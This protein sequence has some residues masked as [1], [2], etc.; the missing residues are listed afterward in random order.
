MADTKAATNGVA[1]GKLERYDGDD[2]AMQRQL[3]RPPDIEQDMKEMER[4]KRVEMIMNSQLFREELERIIESQLSEGYT[5]SS[6]AALQQVTDLLLPH[7][8]KQSTLRGGRCLVPINDMRG[9]DGLRCSKGEKVL[10]CKTAALCRLVDAHGWTSTGF[11]HVTVRL[12]QD[13]EHFLVNP[14]G[15]LY[16][17]VTASSLL[18]LDMQ[19]NVID[20]G[21]TT[22]HFNR[23]WYARH[24][25]VHAGRPD[26]KCL[27]H[28]QHPSCVAVSVLKDGLAVIGTE[29]ALLGDVAYHDGADGRDLAR[30]LGPSS[31]V[32]FVRHHGAV[33][34]GDS[35][36]E[37]FSLLCW[38][39]EACETQMRLL[40]MGLDRVHV[41]SEEAQRAVREE[42]AR[43]R[44]D[45]PLPGGD[46]DKEKAEPKEKA[47][48]WRPCDLLFEAHMRTLDNSGH[49]TGYIYRQPLLR[50]ELPRLK[51]DVEVPPSAS[52][53]SQFLEE[54]KWLSPLKK[55]LDGRKTQDKVRWV[56][57]PNTYQRVEVLETGTQDPK[58]ITK[59]VEVGG[60]PDTWVQDGVPSTSIK[61]DTLHQFV[62]KGTDPG[63]F[64]RKQKELKENRLNSKLNAG[65][66]SN[67]LEGVTWEEVKKM[68][69]A[70]MSG[71]GDQ[72]VMVGA[73][74]KGIIQRD[75]QH[76]AMVYKSAY[77][78]NP[79]D[80][81]SDGELE[82]YRRLV[83][84]K[85]R[86][87]PIEE[88]VPDSIKALLVEP[89]RPQSPLRPS[90]DDDDDSKASGQVRRSL[91]SRLATQAAEDE[92][93]MV[94][95][96]GRRAQSERKPKRH[97]KCDVNGEE[98]SGDVSAASRSSKEVS[99]EGEHGVQAAYG[100]VRQSSPV[101]E[102]EGDKKKKKKGLRTPSFLKKK[103]HRKEEKAA[104]EWQNRSQ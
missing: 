20:S 77:S 5:P 31:K 64:K 101:K 87:E 92:R 9:V 94:Q 39:V 46:E 65:P 99:W 2:P 58:K 66:Q 32:V 100:A 88:E 56:N 62:P 59:W 49:R 104:S 72:V 34:G 15:L 55:L 69:D 16:H 98:K 95:Q 24:A 35:V 27:I 38:M 83:E 26:L 22:F 8:T 12:S 78:K 51:T 13:Q 10:R 4:R 40:P 14:L 84:K 70:V 61:I 81:I 7:A 75:F 103:K 91:S 74:S 76:N 68:Q 60:E 52:S 43:L 79:F 37:A 29:A 96:F 33:V 18:K 97:S 90:D 73:A 48:R 63:E 42:H 3:W 28:V 45:E 80:N 19:G 82:E 36:E 71:T 23:A 47:K 102:V 41:L 50:N 25:A 89:Q 6:M 57:S 53:I 54:D 1:D 17:E 44:T 85:Q 21:T 11:S 67:L 86:G 30:S 93:M